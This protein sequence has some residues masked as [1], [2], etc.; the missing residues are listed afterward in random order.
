[1]EEKKSAIF[2]LPFHEYRVKR[3]LSKIRDVCIIV[4]ASHLSNHYSQFFERS[5]VP[6]VIINEQKIASLATYMLR[7]TMQLSFLCRRR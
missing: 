1:M 6:I 7:D 2:S 3:D 5:K 4:I